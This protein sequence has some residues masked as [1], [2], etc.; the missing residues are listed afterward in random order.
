MTDSPSRLLHIT[1]ATTN[2]AAMAAFYN[3]VFDARIQPTQAYGATLYKG[4]LAGISLLLCPNE[5]AGVAAEQSRHQLQFAV[6]SL[7]DSLDQVRA[8]GGAIEQIEAGG[9]E[10][11]AAVRDP[12]GNTLEFVERP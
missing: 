9:S 1:L 8:A 11:R 2:T 12:D 5:I 7:D 4:T 3:S 10:R 6:A